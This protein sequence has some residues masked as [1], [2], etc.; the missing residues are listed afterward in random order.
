VLN[1]LNLLLQLFDR[2]FQLL[3]ALIVVRMSVLV[4]FFLQHCPP[5]KR[6]SFYWLRA[7]AQIAA[8]HQG[9]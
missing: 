2:C 7:S 4:M 8:I 3:E 9:L 1:F 6:T 5:S